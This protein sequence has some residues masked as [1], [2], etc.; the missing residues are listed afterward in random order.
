MLFST[1]YLKNNYYFFAQALQTAEEERNHF[2]RECDLLKA[3]RRSPSP[4]RKSKMNS[5][6]I[7]SEFDKMRK[8]RDELQLLLDKFERHMA[9]IQSNVKVLTSERD[10]L[11]GMYK[12]SKQ[13]LGNFS[14]ISTNFFLVLYILYSRPFAKRRRQVN[15]ISQIFS[16]RPKCFA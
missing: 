12:E 8:E 7:N 6:E 4:I 3:M 13:E 1:L 16:S 11:A 10:K 9:E 5:D 2:R 15:K 14:W